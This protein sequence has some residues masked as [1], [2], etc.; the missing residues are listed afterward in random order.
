[1]IT[2]RRALSKEDAHKKIR[3]GPKQYNMYVSN[4]PF[5]WGDLEGAT[6]LEYNIAEGDTE[7]SPH[8][9]H[10][11]IYHGRGTTQG[12]RW[13]QFLQQHC[14]LGDCRVT[15]HEDVTAK[16]PE[17]VSR[18]RMEMYV[19]NPI[20]RVVNLAPVTSERFSLLA[21][22]KNDQYKKLQSLFLS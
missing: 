9:H 7:A 8:Y 21:S 17:A 5:R 15:V 3:K 1:M 22:T 11:V 2:T 16:R 20:K 6:F 10:L 12:H 14:D 18:R 4:R 13:Q 19:T